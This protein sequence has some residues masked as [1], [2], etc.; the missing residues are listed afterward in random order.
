[1]LFCHRKTRGAFHHTS[2]LAGGPCIAAGTLVIHDGVLEEL[3]PH[4][5]HYRP[6]EH[7]LHQL[8]ARQPSQTRL[9]AVPRL[10][11]LCLLR[12]CWRLWAARHSRW[13]R[14]AHWAPS[15]GLGC[16]SEPPPKPPMPPPFA[17]QVHLRSCGVSLASVSV[18]VQ[19]VYKVRSRVGGKQV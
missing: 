12:A 17:L 2:F 15:H 8:L 14:P 5:G 7:H 13:E 6:G 16:S 11:L 18:D 4:S 10:R 9:S 1:M 19:R 3:Y